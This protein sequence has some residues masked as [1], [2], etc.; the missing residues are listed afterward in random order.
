[1]SAVNEVSPLLCGANPFYN[2]VAGDFVG[3]VKHLILS[4]PAIGAA[5]GRKSFEALAL[6]LL[7]PNLK[8]S[9]RS[10]TAFRADKKRVE[11]SLSRLCKIGIVLGLAPPVGEYEDGKV[12]LVTLAMGLV[13]L[14]SRSESAA[15]DKNDKELYRLVIAQFQNLAAEHREQPCVSYLDFVRELLQIMNYFAS[16]IP[17]MNCTFTD[18]GQNLKAEESFMHNVDGAL[19]VFRVAVDDVIRKFNDIG[20]SSEV[21]SHGYSWDIVL[22]YYCVQNPPK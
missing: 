21:V 16:S 17:S 5:G 1:M 9:W 6:F 12:S 22:C 18:M 8:Q 19:P 10:G 20:W 11:C 7:Y 13:V 15:G 3:L 4:D 2:P 14:C